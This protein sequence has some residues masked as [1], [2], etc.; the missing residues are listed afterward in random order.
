MFDRQL[1]A[2]KRTGTFTLVED[3]ETND[4]AVSIQRGDCASAV[5]LTSLTVEDRV[6]NH[7]L[8]IF[9]NGE[10]SAAKT[11]QKPPSLSLSLSPSLFLSFSL[12]NVS[13]GQINFKLN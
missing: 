9:S 11:Q 1:V 5:C 13:N 6:G 10:V 8:V 3:V 12:F 2:S 4:F 7:E